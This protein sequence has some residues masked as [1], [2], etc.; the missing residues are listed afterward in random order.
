MSLLRAKSFHKFKTEEISM[1]RE[2]NLWF[3]VE[4]SSNFSNRE[5]LTGAQYSRQVNCITRAKLAR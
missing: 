1:N 5:A 4:F 3:S 2:N